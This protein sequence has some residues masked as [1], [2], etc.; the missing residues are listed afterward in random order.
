MTPN[1]RV[2]VVGGGFAGLEITTWRGG[3]KLLGL[4]LSWRCGNRRPFHAG[5][6]WEAMDLGLRVM[7]RLMAH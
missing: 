1:P 2:V 4:Y 3:K 6:P 7:S 5:P